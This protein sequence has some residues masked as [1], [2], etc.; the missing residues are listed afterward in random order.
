MYVGQE[1]LLHFVGFLS[2]ELCQGTTLPM[3]ALLSGI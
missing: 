3:K 1:I 2:K